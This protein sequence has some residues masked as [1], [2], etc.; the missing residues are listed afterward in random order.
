MKFIKKAIL[1][2]IALLTLSCSNPTNSTTAKAE[3]KHNATIK[4]VVKPQMPNPFK[5]LPRVNVKPNQK[6]SS[7]FK[8]KFNSL[9]IWKAFEGEV[10]KVDLV[11]SDGNQ[12]ATAILH[13]S[14]GKWM[15]SGPA[16]F[17]A[18]LKFK[19]KSSKSG[20]IIFSNDGGPGEGK[21]SQPS[22]SIEIPVIFE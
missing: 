6:L 9:G 4:K 17:E 22:S 10:G 20:K 8:V 12:L 21:E 19:T 18:T 15:T 5:K 1:L 14:D 11:D 13:S 7:P 2:N 3:S 16:L